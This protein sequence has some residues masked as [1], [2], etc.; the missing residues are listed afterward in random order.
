[1][2]LRAPKKNGW[3]SQP[4]FLYLRSLALAATLFMKLRMGLLGNSI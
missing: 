1:M 4:H 2:V 3:R